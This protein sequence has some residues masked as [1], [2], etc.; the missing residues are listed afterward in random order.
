MPTRAAKVE[1]ER[2]PLT[3]ALQILTHLI[4]S[5]M[6][7]DEKPTPISIFKAKYSTILKNVDDDGVALISRNGKRYVIVSEVYMVTLRK[8]PTRSV[9]DICR[10]L[11][12]PERTIEPTAAEMTGASGDF[13][14]P[15]RRP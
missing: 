15:I 4:G 3:H 7:R 10:S 5:V 2:D 1:R 9:A 6:P 13:K 12:R 14:V 8:R 11:P